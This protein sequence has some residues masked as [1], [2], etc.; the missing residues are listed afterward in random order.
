MLPAPSS[1]PREQD[2]F[3]CQ[4]PR[5]QLRLDRADQPIHPGAL[6]RIAANGAQVTIYGPDI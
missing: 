4:Y 2:E 5:R 6:V 1:V 3:P